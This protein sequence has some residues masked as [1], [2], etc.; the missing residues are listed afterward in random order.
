[1][2]RK[3][4]LLL[5]AGAA[6]V[7]LLAGCASRE[8]AKIGIEANQAGT[9]KAME[10]RRG[11][12]AQ[13]GP[14]NVR[15]RDKVYLGDTG[16]KSTNGEPLPL[17]LEGSK[18]VTLN[19]AAPM[20]LVEIARRVHELTGIPVEDADLVYYY[21]GTDAGSGGQGSG[22]QGGQGGQGGGSGQG[23]EISMFD[24][25]AAG[26]A[27][28]TNP[29]SPID[30]KYTGSLSGLLDLISTRYG[31]SWEYKAGVIRFKGDQTRSYT[32][33]AFPTDVT[34][35]N[36]ISGQVIGS[37]QS[38][39]SEGGANTQSQ[40][41]NG[42]TSSVALKYWSTVK[43]TI[44]NIV[45]VSG[46]VAITPETGTVTVTAR[47][48]VQRMVE[49]YVR[50]ENRR[51]GRQVA[52]DVKVLSLTINNSD[53][54]NFNLNALMSSLGKGIGGAFESVA[55]YAVENAAS[56]SVGIL[57]QVT[58]AGKTF[59]GGYE[60]DPE[61][62]PRYIEDPANPGKYMIDPETPGKYLP[63]K[64]SSAIIQALS[65]KGSVSLLTSASV[66]TLNNQPAP[67]Q[68]VSQTGYLAEVEVSTSEG[69]VS[70]ALKPGTVTTGFNMN[71][72]PRILSNGE[73]LLNYN[74]A[75]SDLNA[76]NT[77]SSGSGANSA[78]IQIPDVATR[79]FQ[80]NVRMNNGSTL[81]LGG[82]ERQVNNLSDR[83]TGAS[84]NWLAGGGFKADNQKEVIVILLTPVVLDNP[85]QLAIPR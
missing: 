6:T 63:R 1:M 80:Q 40:A 8:E 32:L 35:T 84:W 83:G 16:V 28:S 54:V 60:I 17:K 73:I 23:A 24:L 19:A 10:L 59:S 47:P 56:L 64:G 21:S 55:P 67:V 31:I 14:A 15:M 50:Q 25:A 70:Q 29:M 39:G 45:G 4:N 51:L 27:S 76:I 68:V 52:I 65:E 30:V 74:V 81:V 49:D 36:T 9:T 18:S 7:A 85:N 26:S 12:E 72:L 2:L 77:F 46:R 53:S 5:I 42:V 79:S 38:G 69:V 57:N 34:Q 20:N 71:L 41:S 37:G 22:G 75:L 13:R 82:F 11:L 78:Q 3:S 33:Y 48:S 44:D 62:S 43:A 66:T 61:D 58:Q